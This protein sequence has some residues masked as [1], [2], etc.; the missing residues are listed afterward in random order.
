[1]KKLLFLAAIILS[2]FN[3][4]CQGFKDPYGS[5]AVKAFADDLYVNGF[6]DE[7]AGEYKRYLFQSNNK[8]FSAFCALANIYREKK[9]LKGMDWLNSTVKPDFMNEDLSCFDFYYAESL[10]LRRDKELFNKHIE[11]SVS[12]QRTKIVFDTTAFI[13][14]KD[15]TSAA[16]AF[17]SYDWIQKDEVKQAISEYTEKSPLLALSL[18]MIIPGSGKW[19]GGSF[20][21]G[22]NSFLTIGLEAYGTYWCY[23]NY[24]INN[25]RTWTMGTITVVSYIVELYGSY[26]NALRVNDANYRRITTEMEKL[27]E[28]YYQP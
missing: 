27:Y 26:Q 18:S 16:K 14:N 3:S 1:M 28:N 22:F 21:S 19:Y 2:C 7:A 9:D 6:Y 4:F 10:F 15:I 13:L 5:E 23:D 12:D 25:W 20:M 11:S 17:E 8:D 24:G